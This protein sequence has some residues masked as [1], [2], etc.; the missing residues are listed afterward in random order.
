M[1]AENSE[2]LHSIYKQDNLGE[3]TAM[4]VFKYYNGR[5]TECE[6]SE[7]RLHQ[8]AEEFQLSPRVFTTLVTQ[9][10]GYRSCY[11]LLDEHINRL[12]SNASSLAISSQVAA[13]NLREHII[14]VTKN[15]LT[16]H[17][18]SQVRT[19]LT[20]DKD[21]LFIQLEDYQ[22]H[23]V[24]SKPIKL[25]SIQT[26]RPYPTIKSASTSVSLEAR[27]AAENN[28][29][30]EALLVSRNQKI[31]EGAWSN[32]FWFDKEHQLY[33]SSEPTLAGVTQARILKS[34]SVKKVSIIIEELL[35]NV[36]EIFITQSSSGII[37]VKNL[38]STNFPNHSQ[39]S[40]LYQEYLKWIADEGI[41]L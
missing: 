12:L 3:N 26:E 30:D 23:F 29:C 31:L 22:P 28:N 39:T 10:V 19:R 13:D 34:K 40:I 38:D 35:K 17:K 33:T 1:S 6:A 41:F 5:L 32:I 24:F 15:L 9:R 14:Q 25:F 27:R 36:S 16:E 8:T 20:L 18:F 21:T 11:F 2:R 7:F 37:A 4:N